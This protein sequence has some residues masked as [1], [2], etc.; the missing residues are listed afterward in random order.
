MKN[1][2]KI[3]KISEARNETLIVEIGDL[4]TGSRLYVRDNGNSK[5]WGEWTITTPEQHDYL[6]KSVGNNINRVS[7][8][9]PIYLDMIK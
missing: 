3:K 2:N 6:I 7:E 1:L 9:G 8:L 5:I 4:N